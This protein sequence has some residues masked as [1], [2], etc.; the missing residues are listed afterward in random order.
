VEASPLTAISPLDGRYRKKVD[1]LSEFFSEYALIHYRLRAEISYLLFLSKKGVIEKIPQRTRSLLK[2]VDKKFNLSDASRVK[3]IENKTNHDVKAI[4]YFLREKVTDGSSSISQYFHIGLTSEDINSVAY[5]WAIRDARKNVLL[6]QLRNL[7]ELVIR[8]AREEKRTVMLARTHGQPAVPTTV[9]K[10]FLVF[11]ARLHKGYEKL[12]EIEIEAK[13]TGAV[14]NYNAHAAAF[15]ETDWISFSSAF[16]KSL[17]LKPNIYTTQI[18]PTDAYIEVFQ[19]LVFINSVLTGFAQDMWR[20]ISDDYFLQAVDNSTVGSSTMPQK[21]NPID[22][23]NCEGNLGVANC[24][25]DFLI[26]KLPISRLQRDLSDSTVKRNIGSAAAYTYLGWQSFVAG[27]N[28]ASI[29]K[30]KLNEELEGHWEVITEGIQTILRASG[31][32]TAYEKLKDFSKGK[33]LTK[34][35]VERFIAEARVPSKVKVKLRKLSPFTYFGLAD[36]LVD[37][38]VRDIKF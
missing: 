3:E 4:E 9:G 1:I 32:A 13:L 29:N 5:S 7:V 31:D 37:L 19:T 21:V 22:F 25:L 6:P 12:R 2:Q 16:I 14:G 11:A 36:R 33:K 8:R 27:L 26:A 35:D 20:Y 23:E 38:G 15:T 34:K 17:G 10:E 24:L 28:K 18:L 30:E